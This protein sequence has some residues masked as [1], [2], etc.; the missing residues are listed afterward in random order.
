MGDAVS[1]VPSQPPRAIVTE[2]KLIVR[3][4]VDHAT[5]DIDAQNYADQHPTE[6][7][8]VISKSKKLLYFFKNGILVNDYVNWGDYEP[9]FANT[10]TTIEM[11]FPVPVALGIDQQGNSTALAGPKRKA[12]DRR[13]P[14]GEYAVCNKR[15]SPSS[16]FTVFLDVSYPNIQDAEAAFSAGIINKA[17]RNSIIQD[18]VIMQQRFA[19]HSGGYCPSG[20]PMGGLIGIH[21]QAAEQYPE[22]IIKEAT[23]SAGGQYVTGSDW[24][25]GCI[26]IENRH[27]RY[28]WQ[29]APIGTRI[30]ILP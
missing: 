4:Q 7:V 17:R 25:F 11:S 5:L 24:T 6:P 18:N 3:P 12:G 27:A 8:I 2:G 23:V 1:L 16:S 19:A 20:G 22:V 26:A 13:T 9:F 29:E 21:P 30:L 10:P 15:Q 28:L 14:E